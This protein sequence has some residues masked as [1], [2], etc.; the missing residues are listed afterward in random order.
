M[1][2]S[3]VQCRIVACS[4]SVTRLTP[5]LWP[6]QFLA[7]GTFLGLFASSSNFSEGF[8]LPI[9]PVSGAMLVSKLFKS[10]CHV[11]VLND[12]RKALGFLLPQKPVTSRDSKVSIAS[13]VLCDSLCPAHHPL[14]SVSE[15]LSLLLL[16]GKSSL[17]R[18]LCSTC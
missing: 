8:I 2:F 6:P 16:S 12:K 9:T 13:A 10:V 4:L 17:N 14:G 15:S 5:P 11:G 3:V 18:T 7:S 1:C